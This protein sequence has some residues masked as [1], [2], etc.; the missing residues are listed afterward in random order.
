MLFMFIRKQNNKQRFI[1]SRNSLRLTILVEPIL[2]I[3]TRTIELPSPFASNILGFIFFVFRGT[4]I[5]LYLNKFSWFILYT[6]FSP[7]RLETHDFFSISIENR[8]IF[9]VFRKCARGKKKRKKKETNSAL[10]TQC[11]AL[12]RSSLFKDFYLLLVKRI[13]KNRNYLCERIF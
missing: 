8:S 1:H 4:N 7:I 10:G 13:W 3:R 12:A 2:Y 5:V 9:H 11:I 6:R